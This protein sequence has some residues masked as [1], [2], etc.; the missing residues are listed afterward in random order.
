LE[1]FV[2]DTAADRH[3]TVMRGR[4]EGLRR[5]RPTTAGGAPDESEREDRSEGGDVATIAY[6]DD[7][8]QQFSLYDAEHALREHR[9]IVHY[10]DK[11]AA[12]LFIDRVLASPEWRSLG[13]PR[14]VVVVWTKHESGV[15]TC[16]KL[17]RKICLPGWA[18]NQRVI[19]HELAHLVTSDGHGPMFAGT[20]LM[21]YG[22]FI[23]RSF[24]S[25]ME[26]EYKRHG[27]KFKRRR[28]AYRK[29]G[30]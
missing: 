22:R 29:E 15:A 5:R 27:V 23:T 18:Y 1:I 11:D 26:S 13:G 21:L 3:T 20:A 28:F 6:S 4:L 14:E 8:P 16:Y 7:D 19:L 30:K 17:E 25:E 2:V 10:K 9:H 12:M 24:Q